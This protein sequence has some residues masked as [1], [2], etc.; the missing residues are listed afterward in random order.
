[1]ERECSAILVEA[2]I[3]VTEL[4]NLGYP[5]AESTE[6][7]V[8]KERKI[9][10]LRDC[11]TFKIVPA[12]AI[13]DD[14]NLI[15]AIFVLSIKSDDV[16][17]KTKARFVIG[18]HRDPMK[19]FIVHQSQNVRPPL[20]RLVLVLAV[21]HKMTVWTSN[22]RQAYLQS[23]QMW[24]KPVFIKDP[25]KE[26]YLKKIKAPQLL[27]S[28]YGLSESGGI[29]YKTLKHRHR[30]DLKMN[31]L[32]TD[33]ALLVCMHDEN[34]IEISGTYMDEIIRARTTAFWEI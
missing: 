17:K 34:L 9:K 13:S 20:I 7:I 5:R 19:K 16:V 18:G 11:G 30:A 23:K 27:K 31:L 22:V 26:F 28:L 33:L 3:C 21:A 24:S 1:M 32:R 10:R 25:A 15:L 4:I 14:A 6:I 29:W 12:K 8:E 2:T